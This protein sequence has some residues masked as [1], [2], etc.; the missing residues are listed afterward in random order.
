LVVLTA[1]DRGGITE[2]LPADLAKTFDGIW[3]DLQAKL[4][5]LS[6]KGRQ[7]IVEGATHDM[8]SEKP[9]VVADAIREVLGQAGG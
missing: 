8:P 4:V 2:G 7:Q 3:M 6:S 5:T 9:D 1:G